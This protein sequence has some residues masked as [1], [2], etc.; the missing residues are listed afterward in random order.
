[1]TTQLIIMLN[2]VDIV[3]PTIK[4]LNKYENV[5]KYNMN[6]PTFNLGLALV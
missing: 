1:M 6:W 2:I 3:W 4:N 5:I